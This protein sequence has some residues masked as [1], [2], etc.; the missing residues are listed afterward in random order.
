M[1]DENDKKGAYKHTRAFLRRL[2][3]PFYL[4]QRMK[5]PFMKA[6]YTS[7]HGYAERRM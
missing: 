2:C 6:D 5:R 7:S 3:V 4:S 1:P